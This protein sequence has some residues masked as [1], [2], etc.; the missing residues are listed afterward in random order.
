[1]AQMAVTATVDAG[2][3]AFADPS[4]D[5]ARFNRHIPARCVWHPC[6]ARV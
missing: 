4:G 3:G 1:M 6:P 5:R 2:I